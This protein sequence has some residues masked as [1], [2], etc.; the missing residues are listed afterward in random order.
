MKR[1]YQKCQ[2]KNFFPKHVAEVGVYLPETSNVVDFAKEGVRTTLVEAHPTYVEAIEK[3]FEA[4]PEVT[5]YPV[6]IYDTP[7]QLKIVT[8]G[9]STYI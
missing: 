9:A 4:Y 2:Q 8:R 6:A 3:Y 7:G 1:I 5:I